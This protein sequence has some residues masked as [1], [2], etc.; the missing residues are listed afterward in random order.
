MDNLIIKTLEIT[1][2]ELVNIILPINR[3]S[4]M[5]QK[6]WIENFIKDFQEK[7]DDLLYDQKYLE[8]NNG[9][10]LK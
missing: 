8:L 4:E 9:W 7:Y 10:S 2:D 6:N 5:E 1:A 3:H